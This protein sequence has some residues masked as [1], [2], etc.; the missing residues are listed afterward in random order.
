[1][2]SFAQ[3]FLVQAALA[4]VLATHVPTASWAG[5]R[6]TS[7][8]KCELGGVLTFSDRPCGTDAVPLDQ[9]AMN[10]YEAPQSA[11]LPKQGIKAPASRRVATRA[12]PRDTRSGDSRRGDKSAETKRVESCA[13]LARGLKEIRGKMR[14][15]YSAKEGERLRI[16]QDKVRESQRLARCG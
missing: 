13:K 11:S 6:A 3:D 8:Y 12:N 9:S 1:M 5:E 2:S 10:T 7:I 15:G 4:L 16:R 14:S